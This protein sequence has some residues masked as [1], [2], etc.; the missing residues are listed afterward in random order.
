MFSPIDKKVHF[1]VGI[2]R[3]GTTLLSQL[4]NNHKDLYSMP[5]ATFM[6]FFMHHF[7]NKKSLSQNEIDLIFEQIN[8]FSRSHPWVGWKF[9]PQ[10]CR[11]NL[12]NYLLNNSY[13]FI[14][15]CK[16]I[17]DS[18]EQNNTKIK[19]ETSIF[20]DKNPSYTL[21]TDKIHKLTPDSKFVLIVRDFKSV[22]SSQVQSVYFKEKKVIFEA[23]RW[24][25][26]YEQALSSFKKNK[27]DYILVKYENL[28]SYPEKEL[29][30]IFNFLGVEETI[31]P[32]IKMD[33]SFSENEN[34]ISEKYKMRFNKK[35][36][37]LDK[38]IFHNRLNPWMDVLSK[39][40]IDCCDCICA[41]TAS[42]MGYK[43]NKTGIIKS[44]L[45]HFKYISPIIGAKILIRKNRILY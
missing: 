34:G 3:S 29:I 40:E 36:G 6:L 33:F 20:L 27:I 31:F 11:E 28:V 16:I 37:D 44:F 19:N 7:K 8:L 10:F 4:L 42:K 12:N 22:I 26:F 38:D 23:M 32:S 9:N 2:G 45:I 21:Y 25:L 24:K 13:N 18:F 1:V 17:Y 35:Y 30:R 43:E 39:N 5:E 15:I 14:D 41:L